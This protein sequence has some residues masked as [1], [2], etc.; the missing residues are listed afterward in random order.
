MARAIIGRIVFGALS[1]LLGGWPQHFEVAIRRVSRSLA[2][3]DFG[4]P[5]RDLIAEEGAIPA[6]LGPHRA[7]EPA[8][9]VGFGF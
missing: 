1:Q 9:I 4:K 8:Q 2:C 7:R 5:M 6:M 3:A